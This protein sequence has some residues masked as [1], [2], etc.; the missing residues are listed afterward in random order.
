MA[1]RGEGVLLASTAHTQ[2][3]DASVCQAYTDMSGESHLE[4]FNTV[5]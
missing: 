1:I 2:G 5:L 3:P 4:L